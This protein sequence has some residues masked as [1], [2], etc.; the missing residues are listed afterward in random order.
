MLDIGPRDRISG[1]DL[2]DAARRIARGLAYALSQRAPLGLDVMR[3]CKALFRERAGRIENVY[4]LNLPNMDA[5]LHRYDL[6]AA[7]I[8]RLVLS[9]DG[10]IDAETGA[11]V[12]TPVRLMADESR[13]ESRSTLVTFILIAAH[14]HL[15]LRE[16]ARL[17]DPSPG[18]RLDLLPI[19][20]PPG[21][22]SPRL[23]PDLDPGPPASWRVLSP[24]A[25]AIASDDSAPDGCAGARRQVIA[26]DRLSLVTADTV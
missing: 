24:L 25:M 3:D 1:R 21:T 17:L 18:A 6:H 12:E 10:P 2:W 23:A 20:A 5:R 4:T 11:V 26:R 13:L 16:Q 15:S 19:R 9:V 22:G 7:G 14:D 8:L